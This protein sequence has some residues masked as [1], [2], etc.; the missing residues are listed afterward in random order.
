M[1]LPL[2]PWGNDLPEPIGNCS[3]R[4]EETESNLWWES[5]PGVELVAHWNTD[6]AIPTPCPLYALT[7]RYVRCQ[8][9][10]KV[11]VWPC[12]QPNCSVSLFA[13]T[14][15]VYWWT[16]ASKLGRLQTWS[17]DHEVRFLL[18][19]SFQPLSMWVEMSCVYSVS[20]GPG[21]IGGSALLI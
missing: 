19:Q 20:M 6:W 18:V 1:P 12:S 16:G 4:C 14:W 10:T 17:G 8:K 2:Y 7:F 13:R 9:C 5:N 3:G 11:H 15:D 21:K